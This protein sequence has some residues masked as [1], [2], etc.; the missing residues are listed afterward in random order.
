M[1]MAAIEPG[2]EHPNRHADDCEREERDQQ[3]G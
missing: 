3:L 2:D 1:R